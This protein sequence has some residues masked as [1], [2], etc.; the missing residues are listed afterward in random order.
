MVQTRPTKLPKSR[1][2]IRYVRSAKVQKED[3]KNLAVFGNNRNLLITNWELDDITFDSYPYSAVIRLYEPLPS[4]IQLKHKFHIV[5]EITPPIIENVFLESVGGD[6]DG[7]I[8]RPPNYDVDPKYLVDASRPTQ[9]ETWN[10]LVS[11][12]VATSE[13]IIDKMVSDATASV[14]INV[15]YSDWGEFINY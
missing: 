3:L 14:H 10:E 1:F 15:D 8:L 2:E 4:D 5:R 9:Y 7:N 11:G 13:Q 6:I 12:D